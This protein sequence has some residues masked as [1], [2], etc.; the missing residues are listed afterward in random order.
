MASTASSLP[1]CAARGED[2]GCADLLRS[3]DFLFQHV[4]VAPWSDHVLMEITARY[5]WKIRVAVQ[6]CATE[7][8]ILYTFFWFLSVG[9]IRMAIVVGNMNF[10]TMK[11]WW[12]PIFSQNCAC[13]ITMYDVHAAFSFTLKRAFFPL[14]TS[15]LGAWNSQQLSTSKWSGS[16]IAQWQL[17][18][19]GRELIS[20]LH[21]LKCDVLTKETGASL[22][23][24]PQIASN[25]YIHV[26]IYIYIYISNFLFI[27]GFSCFF[28]FFSITFHEITKA[29][30][31]RWVWWRA[32]TWVWA[33]SWPPSSPRAVSWGSTPG[34]CK[35]GGRRRMASM[36]TGCL[37]WNPTWWSM[38][39]RAF[40]DL[41]GWDMLRCWEKQLIALEF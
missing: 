33:S 29:S 5:P 35:G 13:M 10:S 28:S 18:L 31:L 24:K 25:N 37:W 8:H 1:R 9:F 6:C 30:R 40:C 7:W 26:Y 2:V 22:F 27:L 12:Y 17:Q 20:H 3:G 16:E 39:R 36:A 21:N 32:W 11:F 15:S 34:C 14:G 23:N 19:P 4:Y 41:G 38:P